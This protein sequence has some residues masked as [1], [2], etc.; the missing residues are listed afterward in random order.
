MAVLRDGERLYETQEAAL[1]VDV[2]RQPGAYRIEARLPG[3]RAG[4]VPWLLTNPMY[5]GVREAH[6]RE[7]TTARREPATVRTPIATEM[8]AAE[9]SEG[10][11]STLAAIQLEDGT[12]AVEWLFTLAP[13]ARGGQYAAMRFPVTGG[14]AAHDRLQLRV[15]SSRPM[16]VWAQLRAPGGAGLERWGKSFYV[17]ENLDSVELHFRDFRPFESWSAAE[18]PLDRV[19]ALLLVVDTVNTDPGSAGRMAITDL[20]FAR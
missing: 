11:G 10:S 19:D 9:S 1:R 3:Q 20:W 17:D 13:G 15:R 2:G 16:R 14:L 18:P 7:A 6:V 4:S 8:W 12:P 5:V